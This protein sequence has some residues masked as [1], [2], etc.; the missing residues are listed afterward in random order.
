MQ[1][2]KYAQ[3]GQPAQELWV[4]LELKVIADVEMCIRDSVSSPDTSSVQKSPA[5]NP[6]VS[7]FKTSAR[8]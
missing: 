6:F 5:D 2:P 3:P 8:A 7:T 1:I 4:S